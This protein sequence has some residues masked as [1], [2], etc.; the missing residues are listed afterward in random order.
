MY[1]FGIDIHGGDFAPLEIIKGVDLILKKYK[2][3]SLVLYGNEK[4]IK[5]N[6]QSSLD[7]VEIVHTEVFLDMGEKDPITYLRKNK[8]CSLG[9]LLQDAAQ[10][11]VDGIL[12]AG[13]T[14]AVIVGAHLFVK[15]L[16]GVKRTALCPI[17]PSL[18]KKGKMLLDVG[19]NVELK[20]EHLHDLATIASIT[21]KH[22]LG[23][24][25][26]K[27]GLLNI[28]TEPGKGRDV[29]KEVYYLLQDDQSIDFYGNVETKEL[30]TSECNILLTDGF[31]GNMV[32]KA[33]EGTAKGMSQMLKECMSAN[34]WGKLGYIIARNNFKA[35]KKRMDPNEIGGAMLLGINVP[36]V[37]AHGSSNAYAFMNAF[38]QV[39]NLVDNQ[40]IEKIKKGLNINE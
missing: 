29:D 35:L 21:A 24:K 1:K 17:I 36:L 5:E 2:D 34:I 10:Q 39:Y 28:G 14:Q 22:A 16:P 30:F 3:V 38:K 12:T 18:D 37:K 7:R 19:A 32:M 13:P 11:K 8:N 26:A 40:I 23:Y 4:I 25:E 6:L 27:L 15:R 31:T 9:L 20:A 33:M